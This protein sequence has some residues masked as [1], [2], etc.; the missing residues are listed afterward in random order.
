MRRIKTVS[1]H[2]HGRLRRSVMVEDVASR[3]GGLKARHP[4]LTRRFSSD[5]QPLPGHQ[6]AWFD[7]VLQGCEVRR[8]DLETIDAMQIEVFAQ[9]LRIGG[10]LW[11]DN[12]HTAAGYQRWV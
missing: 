3:R 8:C 1:Q 11:R 10:H 9:E 12:V 5:N 2:A 6:L 4:V 7:P